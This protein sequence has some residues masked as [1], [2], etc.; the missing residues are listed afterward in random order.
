MHIEAQTIQS[1]MPDESSRH[2][3]TWLQW[4]H[5]YTYGATYRNRLDATW[6]DMARALEPG[7]KV[8]VIAYDATERTRI[9]NLLVSAGVPLS[10]VDFLLRQTDDCW[11]RDNGPIF[12]YATNN[13]LRITD[14]G[15][16]GWGDDTPY[17]KDNT[18]P[19]GVAPALGLTRVDLNTTVLEGGSIEVDSGVLMA[20]R[21]S[22]LEPN[23]N[24]GLTQAQLETILTANLGV[25]KFIW[26]DGAPGGTDDITD[27]HID[28]FAKFGPNRTIVT[29]SNA[30][31]TYWLVPAADI[32][33]LSAATD[34]NGVAYSFVRL[35][36]TA[37]D[38]TTTYGR[39]LGYKG[40]YVNYYVGNTVVLVP[41]YSDPNDTPARN[42]LQQ[43]YPERT[44]VGIDVR[45]LYR[46]GGM[47]HCVTQQ[48]PESFAHARLNIS[49]QHLD[50]TNIEVT[51]TGEAGR[52]YRLQ[53]TT[54]LPTNWS[55][56]SSFTLTEPL[57]NISVTTIGFIRRFFRTVTP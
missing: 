14:W 29:M 45:N 2:E 51:V 13:V 8:H 55:D 16:D 24:P 22:I 43:L 48:Q 5:H 57:T 26:L 41:T 39:N 47:V 38:V 6:V 56:L 40:S 10:N 32:A 54:N 46:N 17:T 44:V 27:M 1:R 31:L 53:A 35:P 15:F 33:A 49:T 12:V 52:D 50:S 3:G 23:R 18:V 42:I 9:T 19:V 30:D 25:T 4:P 36:L 7:E 11:V 37:N 34:V 28:G 20:T 21:S